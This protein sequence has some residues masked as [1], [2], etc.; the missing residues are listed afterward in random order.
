M[1]FHHVRPVVEALEGFDMGVQVPIPTG[2]IPTS[3]ITTRVA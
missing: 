2:A 1:K 3:A